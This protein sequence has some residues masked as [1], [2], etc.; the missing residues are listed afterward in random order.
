LAVLLLLLLLVEFV[1]FFT[2]QSNQVFLN[3]TTD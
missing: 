2:F 3:T 1:N